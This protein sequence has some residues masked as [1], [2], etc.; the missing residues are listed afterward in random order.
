MVSSSC[1]SEAFKKLF[2]ERMLF[3]FLR[4]ADRVW[5]RN[6]GPEWKTAWIR[7]L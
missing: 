5:S 6:K 1:D 4:G 3:H 7:A 2:T